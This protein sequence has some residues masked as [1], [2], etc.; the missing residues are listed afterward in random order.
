[1]YVDC[2]LEVTAAR[3]VK[4]LYKKAMAGEI[5]QFTGVT[6][7]YEPPLAPEILIHSDQ[8]KPRE[9]ADRVWATLREL[10]LISF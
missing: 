9:S 4:G 5:A 8:E 10:G 2:P 7:P 3:D 6:D 1:M